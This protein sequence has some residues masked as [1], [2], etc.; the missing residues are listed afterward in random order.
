MKSAPHAIRPAGMKLPPDIHFLP[1]TAIS[2][3]EIKRLIAV[4]TK[5]DSFAFHFLRLIAPSAM[6]R[7]PIPPPKIRDLVLP[8]MA[9]PASPP[10][11][12]NSPHGSVR[13]KSCIGT[14]PSGFSPVV[15]SAGSPPFFAP[16]LGWNSPPF[17]AVFA[18]ARATTRPA[19]EVGCSPGRPN[20]VCSP[21]WILDL[22]T[23]VAQ[24]RSFSCVRWRPC[25]GACLPYR[26]PRAPWA[27]ETS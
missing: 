11:A 23:T 22:T 10:K 15:V 17:G 8:A 2:A 4:S 3:T 19:R 27:V 26:D 16:T 6:S 13:Q 18:S 24:R 21:R 20:S 25:G 7:V 5:D 14:Q 1:I 12:T 9:N